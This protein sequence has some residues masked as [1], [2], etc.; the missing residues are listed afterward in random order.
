MKRSLLISICLNQHKYKQIFAYVILNKFLAFKKTNIFSV[1]SNY[2][3][4]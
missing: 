4:H 1:I 2:L 3:A